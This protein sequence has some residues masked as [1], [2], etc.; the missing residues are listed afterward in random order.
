L[1]PGEVPAFLTGG[2]V[3]PLVRDAAPRP[4]GAAAET[5][6]GAGSDAESADAGRVG[7]R[8]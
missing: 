2:P 6:A 7:R 1:L 8:A 4:A 3:I 5:G